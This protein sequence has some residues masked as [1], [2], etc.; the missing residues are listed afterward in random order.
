[1]DLVSGAREDFVRPCDFSACL[2]LSS[3]ALSTTW[4]NWDGL[5]LSVAEEG[6]VEEDGGCSD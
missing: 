2:A 4:S 5:E 1:M 6:S 3:G